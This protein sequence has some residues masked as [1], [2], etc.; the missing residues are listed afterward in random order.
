VGGNLWGPI[1]SVECGTTRMRVALIKPIGR[2]MLRP[3]GLTTTNVSWR[4]KCMNSGPE[5]S[6]SPSVSEADVESALAL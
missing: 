4:P 2:F 1:L 5:R 3:L 6:Q